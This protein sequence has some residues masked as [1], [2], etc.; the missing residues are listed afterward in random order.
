MHNKIYHWLL[1][2]KA[3]YNRESN[4]LTIILLTSIIY[5]KCDGNTETYFELLGH[6]SHRFR[7]LHIKRKYALQF[8]R[9][10]V[11]W[12]FVSTVAFECSL[13][14]VIK[15]SFYGHF[16][17]FTYIFLNL[18]MFQRSRTFHVSQLKDN[19]FL[20]HLMNEKS[21]SFKKLSKKL[22]SV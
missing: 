10:T 19:E 4:T 5:Q 1:R 20:Y 21:M 3:T 15:L 11:H 16:L 8:S 2:R 14:N 17:L 18:Y 22:R 13:L 7:H 9:K 6:F 12:L